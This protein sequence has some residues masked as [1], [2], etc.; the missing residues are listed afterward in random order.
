MR[1]P[2]AFTSR[3]RSVEQA[4]A[5]SLALGSC[6]FFE[7]KLKRNKMF[8]HYLHK[9]TSGRHFVT[10]AALEIALSME[11][12]AICTFRLLEGGNYAEG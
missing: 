10:S 12:E 6:V 7:M 2:S 8:H 11:L 5:G 9:E 4:P 3:I 1:N